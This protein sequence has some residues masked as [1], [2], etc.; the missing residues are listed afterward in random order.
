MCTD[1]QFLYLIG[2]LEGDKCKND[3]YRFEPQTDQWISL[4]SLQ[5]E[6]NQAAAVYFDKKIY[7]FG[8]SALNRCL[9]SCEIFHLSSNRWSFGASMKENR[10]G[11]GAILYHDK[12]FVIGGS[13]GVTALTTVEIFNPITCE[14]LVHINSFSHR[15]NIPRIGLGVGICHDR[16]YVIGGFDGR[17]FL[18]SVEIFDENA[19]QWSTNRSNLA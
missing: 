11:C 15:L 3:F 17:H 4:P 10:R 2:G 6:R 19:Q 16:L 9:S 7:V 14:W 13:N 8:G 5:Q 18:K 1:G 12:I